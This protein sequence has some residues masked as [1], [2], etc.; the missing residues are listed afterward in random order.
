MS[1]ALASDRAPRV[2]VPDVEPERRCWRT[3]KWVVIPLY[4]EFRFCLDACADED[5]HI[6]PWWID[7]RRDALTTPWR[8]GAVHGPTAYAHERAAAFCNPPYGRP[9]NGFPGTGAFV[10]R[11]WGQCR[12][13]QV[14][15]VVLVESATDT[16]W[17]RRAFRR[18]DEV[19][20]LPR[21]AFLRPDGS[22]G[23]QPPGGSTV[24]VFRPHVPT[25]GYPGG[26]RVTLW[27]VRAPGRKA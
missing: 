18:S 11:A 5:N 15:V 14:V 25:E 9:G 1:R 8:P 24:F 6:G 16:T 26:P 12:E 21:V 13:Q 27:D 2:D 19:R 7:R 10:D 17:W 20:L 4:Q 22:P 3:P 23:K